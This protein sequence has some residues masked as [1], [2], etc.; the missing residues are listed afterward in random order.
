MDVPNLNKRLAWGPRIDLDWNFL[1]RTAVLLDYTYSQ[2]FWQDNFVYAVGGGLSPTD[3]LGERLGVPNGSM[4]QLT[5][6]L[7]GQISR[8][9]SLGLVGG[10]TSMIYD[11]SSVLDDALNDGIDGASSDIDTA[12]QG[13]GADLKFRCTDED[14]Y[15]EGF[16]SSLTAKVNLGIELSE[17]SRIALTYRRDFQDVFFTNYVAFNQFSIAADLSLGQRVDLDL[18][19]DYRIED[20]EGE[21]D[22]TDDLIRVKANSQIDLVKSSEGIVALDLGFGW[23]RRTG[24]IFVDVSERNSTIEFDDVSVTAGISISR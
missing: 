9:V 17:E 19:A 24:S 11:E 12:S 3:D 8:R 22:R 23:V 21:V 7:E 16:P 15:C 6:G 1:P 5:T 20:Y 13:F 14:E 18:G 10:V 2:F 4:S